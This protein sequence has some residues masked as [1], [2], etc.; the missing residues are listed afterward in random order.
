MKKLKLLLLCL[1]FYFL[2]NGQAGQLN[3]INI[4]SFTVKNVLPGT[5]DSWISTPGALILVAQR[6]PGA[7][8][9]ETLLVL[10]IRSGSA[11][12][13]GSTLATA[14]PID[15]F[16]VRTFNT[17]D[18]VG[19]LGNCHELKEGTYTICAQFYNL[20]KIAVSREVCKDF[21]V[22]ASNVEYAPP[23]LITPENEKKFTW[24]QLEG[25][26]TFRWTPLVPKPKEVVTY[27]L[28]VWQLMQGQNATQAMRTNTP[29]IQKDV[30]NLTQTTVNSVLTGPCKPPYLC[31]FIW[32]VQALNRAGKPMGNNNGT[33]E[34]YTF[35]GVQENT[36]CPTNT[37]PEDKK[38]ISLAEAKRSITFKWTNA[39]APGQ[40]SMY[41]LRVWQ[42]MQGQTGAQAMK[43]SPMVTREV[44][45]A[46]EVTVNGIL[47]GPCKPPYL[48]DFIWDVEMI[49]AAGRSTCHSEPTTFKIADND[50]DIQIDSFDVSCCKNGKQDIYLKLKNNLANPVKIT[51]I[52]IDKVN[53]VTAS[54][55]PSPLTPA[56]P[57]TI[58]GNGTQ[59]F[60]GK[61]NCIDTAKI[62]RIW[63]AAEDPVD[64]AITETEV[65]SD[66]L[67]CRCDA[68]DEKNFI[69]KTPSPG[70]ISTTS[71]SISFNQT[72]TVTTTPAKTIKTIDAELVYFEMI[73]END[74]CIPCDKDA[75]LYGH[76]AG[77]SNGQQWNGPQTSLPINITTPVTPCCSTTFRWCIRYKITFTDCTVCSKV[78]C[79][80]KK[81]TGCTP[82]GGGTG[83]ENPNH[84]NPK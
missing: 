52:K 8:V 22:E 82:T 63:V 76:F 80:E 54:I 28:R 46:T 56:L 77:G 21:R 24:T 25:P 14:R 10:Q 62:I 29:L 55:V 48:C 69:L 6:V 36:N 65:E 47:T 4:P 31:D 51:Q 74:Q 50:I 9:K 18:L 73:P 35:G 79:Y 20:D 61:I 64:N 42:L 17:A 33:S 1:P 68:C 16:D 30:E 49:D 39:A 57:V 27:R 3:Q 38:K 12:I 7:R 84:N 40:A 53:G 75:G 59:I 2:A 71:N 37:A 58:P 78:I 23:T 70:Q 13:C 32:N 81:K 11:M 83:T 26:V 43:S 44:R 66:T 41:R 15:A 5:V 60:T 72:I 45:N 67:H 34:P 19:I